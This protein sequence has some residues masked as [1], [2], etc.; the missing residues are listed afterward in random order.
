[1]E[2]TYIGYDVGHKGG[3][4]IL[5]PNDKLDYCRMPLGADGKPDRWEILKL[6]YPYRKRKDVHLIFEKLHGMPNQKL[7]VI[8][9]LGRQ[10]GLIEMLMTVLRISYT[11][12]TPQKWQKEMFI[13]IPE[14]SKKVKGKLKRDTKAMSI[15]ASKKLFPE[16]SF[17]ATARSKVPHDGIT[18]ATLMAEFGRRKNL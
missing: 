9:Q 2:K 12:V 18:D 13:G 5:H 3:I 11:E 6:L 8:W 14:I 17:L 10:V 4:V 1:M 15:M 16:Y 7:S